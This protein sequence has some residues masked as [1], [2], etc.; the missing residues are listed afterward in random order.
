MPIVFSIASR[1]GRFRRL[2]LAIAATGVLEALTVV[3]HTDPDGVAGHMIVA[4][5]RRAAAAVAASASVLRI[6]TDTMSCPISGADPR[7]RIAVRTSP[8]VTR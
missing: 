5:H 2:Q 6:C 8:C 7:S 4:G 1:S 3:P